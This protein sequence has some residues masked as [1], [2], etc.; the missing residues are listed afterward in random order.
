MEKIFKINENISKK[1]G[2]HRT[3]LFAD[4]RKPP[5]VEFKLCAGDKSTTLPSLNSKAFSKRLK[6]SELYLLKV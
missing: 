1:Y 2:D 3:E 4:N 6:I 5:S